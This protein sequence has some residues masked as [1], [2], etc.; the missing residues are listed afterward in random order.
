[1]ENFKI[2]EKIGELDLPKITKLANASNW[3]KGKRYTVNCSGIEFK[4]QTY[5]SKAAEK[6]EDCFVFDA[7]P[8]IESMYARE[9]TDKEI[10]WQTNGEPQYE[11]PRFDT[12][13]LTFLDDDQI[14]KREDFIIAIANLINNQETMEA[15]VQYATKKKDGTLHKNRVLRIAS[16]GV[17]SFFNGVY[18]IVAR[19]KTDTS[20]SVTFEEVRCKPGDNE[21]WANDFIS[22]YHE[23]L[24]ISEAIKTLFE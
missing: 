21:L 22:T 24:L 23:G 4:I 18:A 8:A 20:L 2:Y 13:K 7:Y 5:F 12:D 1:M 17:A 16:T 19:A 10:L 6:L 14:K 9:L 11:S 15:I 3:P